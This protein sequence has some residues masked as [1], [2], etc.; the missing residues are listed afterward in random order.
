MLSTS[1]SL[2][3]CLMVMERWSWL[4]ISSTA[5]NLESCPQSR[6]YSDPSTLWYYQS[7]SWAVFLFSELPSKVDEFLHILYLSFVYF[8]FQFIIILCRSPE[9]HWLCFP[10]V[11]AHP[12]VLLLCYRWVHLNTDLSQDPDPAGSE[13]RSGRIRIQWSGIRAW[14]NNKIFYSMTIYTVFRKKNIHSCFWL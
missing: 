7:I 6:L 5:P 2:S 4:Q 8:E 3:R 13:L 1:L 12:I 11:Y 10:F 14:K 9:R